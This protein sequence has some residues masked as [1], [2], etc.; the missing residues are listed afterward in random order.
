[1][2]ELFK[3]DSKSKIR[4]WKIYTSGG[5]LIQESG[6]ID[7]KKVKHS[8][9]CSEKNFGRSNYRTPTEQA[10]LEM[11]SEI[12]S[13]LD[14]GYFETKEEAEN[15]AVILPVLAKD[16][17]EHYKKVNWENAF[18]QRKYDGMRCLAHCK[19]NGTVTLISRDGKIIQNMN[20]IIKDLS[21]NIKEDIILDGELWCEGS[22]QDNMKLIKKYRKGESE[23][24][25]YNI[26]DV[27]NSEYCFAVRYD[28]LDKYFFNINKNCSLK[29]VETI[30][31]NNEN[32]LIEYHKQFISEGFE[33]SMI[34]HS[35][36]GYQINKR[37]SDLLKYKDFQDITA[38]IIDI[39][40]NEVDPTQ[41]TPVLKYTNQ[42]ISGTVTSTFK[43]GVKMSH[44]DR[45]DLLKNKH[46]YIG[47]TA[48]IRFFEWT[49]EGKPRFPIM[50]GIRL[51]K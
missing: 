32:E 14:E 13:K 23:K 17:K 27:V 25:K 41:G 46:K 9:L 44:E 21:E 19:S 4:S 22:F 15:E 1:M 2:K 5:E 6:L 29:L 49:D 37:S 33:G 20:H 8:K 12:K 43:A 18:I 35:L 26:Y 3:K 45:Q 16:Y 30:A 28:I 38:E 31:I 51:D 50:H 39:I 47:K 36:N 48:E 24:I 42:K 40:P 7:G 11:E 34:R 10:L